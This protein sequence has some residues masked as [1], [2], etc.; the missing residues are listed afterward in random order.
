MVNPF[1][2]DESDVLR[3]RWLERFIKTLSP[4]D[5]KIKAVLTQGSK[6]ANEVIGELAKSNT[7]S[8]G[9]RTAQIKL[10]KA[11]IESL[12]SG[13]F[14][15]VTPIIKDGQSSTAIAAAN[16]LTETDRRFLAAA[17]SSTND[18]NTFIKSQ[19]QGASLGVANAIS[20]VTGSDI[21]LSA[22]VYRTEKLANR[23]VQ[24]QVNSSIIRGDG[25]KDIAKIVRTSIKPTTPGGVSYAALRLGRTELNNSFHCT[26]IT[27]SENRPWIQGMDWHLSHTHV[28]NI[29]KP[30]ICEEYS[31]RAWEMGNVPAKPHPQCLPGDALVSAESVRAVSQRWY[32]GSFIDVF[33]TKDAPTMSGT[34]N[35]PV[36]T[37]RG[38]VPL[39][40]LKH[41]D[42]VAVDVSFDDRPTF[43]DPNGKYVKSRIQDVFK[44]LSVSGSMSSVSVP[45][46]TEQF[47][48]DGFIGHNVDIVRADSL[49]QNGRAL[50]DL[51]QFLFLFGDVVLPKL[52]SLSALDFAFESIL[53]SANSFI[54]S[55][56]AILPFA[57]SHV[58]GGLGVSSQ[59]SS[60]FGKHVPDFALGNPQDFRSFLESHS[61]RIKLVSP[62]RI[63]NRPGGYKGHVYNLQTQDE[64]YS[65]DTM[66]SHN[67]RCYVTPRLES[68]DS[69]LNNLTMGQYTDW[70]ED[71][72]A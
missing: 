1:S 72:A 7:F 56:S 25:A 32:E 42:Q 27:L 63:V 58:G 47:H 3:K 36:L 49:L 51:R 15:N 30:E 28:V 48:G 35:H 71:N 65:S 10:A 21:P 18:V 14:K 20:R 69:F 60:G 17:F 45:G 70:I 11:E 37:K 16:A 41:T 59:S 43:I 53:S 26:A 29:H 54:G 33:L 55:P 23:W 66:I 40:E 44:T 38:W 9:V 52:I 2:S 61:G 5:K 8:S 34:P 13:V 67:C 39:S 12:L 50:E 22:R 64:W 46:A 57:E 31:R 62:V 6:D 24:N 4:Y 19:R 68:F